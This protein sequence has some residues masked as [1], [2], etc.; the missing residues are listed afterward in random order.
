MNMQEFLKERHDHFV[1]R[2]SKDVHEVEETEGGA[3]RQKVAVLVICCRALRDN[4]IQGKKALYTRPKSVPSILDVCSIF[5][6][7]L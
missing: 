7:I 5:D 2:T 6:I 1:R 3:T 4:I